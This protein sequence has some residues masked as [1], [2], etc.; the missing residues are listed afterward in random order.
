MKNHY[1]VY[2]RILSSGFKG[3]RIRLEGKKSSTRS[4]WQTETGRIAP[5]RR[6]WLAD[7]NVERSLRA[8]LEGRLKIQLSDEDRTAP[9]SDKLESRFG[10]GLTLFA[11]PLRCDANMAVR[12]ILRYD[13]KAPEVAPKRDSIDWTSRINTRHGRH[14]S[15]SVE[16]SGHK[17]QGLPA[18][19]TARVSL[20]AAF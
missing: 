15:L 12:R 19:H 10:P 14:T 16:Y 20:S 3:M 11:G 13:T 6:M 4:E 9:R 17:Y 1:E 2:G 18:V 5:T 7:L 8:G